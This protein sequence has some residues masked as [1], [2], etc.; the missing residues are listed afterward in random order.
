MLLKRVA[1][2]GRWP[3]EQLYFISVP[4]VCWA[5]RLTAP[6]DRFHFS[7]HFLK[8][9]NQA[10]ISTCLIV[11]VRKRRKEGRLSCLLLVDESLVLLIGNPWEPSRACVEQPHSMRV[12]GQNSLPCLCEHQEKQVS[13][14]PFL[15]LHPCGRSWASLARVCALVSGAPEIQTLP[16]VT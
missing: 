16:S 12:G 9:K 8:H 2:H 1:T 5:C 7:K 11:A 10:I 3:L 6:P 13:A 4:Q 14:V 15:L